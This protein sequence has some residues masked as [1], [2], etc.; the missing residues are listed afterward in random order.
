MTIIT[1]A[2]LQPGD[3][4][5]IE[6]MFG[7]VHRVMTAIVDSFSPADI[8]GRPSGFFTPGHVW[9]GISPDCTIARTD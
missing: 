6:S 9:V 3:R 7:D 2:E 8:V 5:R 1:A 4:V